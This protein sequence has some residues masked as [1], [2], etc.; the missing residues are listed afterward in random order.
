M[1]RVFAVNESI[2]Y[3]HAHTR[4]CIYIHKYYVKRISIMKITNTEKEKKNVQTCR[5]RFDF[6]A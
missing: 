5:K 1:P 4:T 3:T 2:V 6:F